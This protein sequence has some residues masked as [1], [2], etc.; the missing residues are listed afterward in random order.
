MRRNFNHIQDISWLHPLD[1][2][3][4]AEINDK[5]ELSQ[6]KNSPAQ[7]TV[8]NNMAEKRNYNCK[9]VA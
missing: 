7:N 4:Y 8:R 1:R 3:R 5:L 2:E 9:D 6:S